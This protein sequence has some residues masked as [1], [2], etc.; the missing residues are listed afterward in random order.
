M[1]K[2]NHGRRPMKA[3]AQTLYIEEPAVYTGDCCYG[4]NTKTQGKEALA[5]PDPSNHG[6]RVLPANLIHSLGWGVGRS[7]QLRMDSQDL[8]DLGHLLLLLLTVVG[9]LSEH[10]L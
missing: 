1:V 4:H 8:K 9:H 5:S 7:P 2:S 10:H 3:A 6:T